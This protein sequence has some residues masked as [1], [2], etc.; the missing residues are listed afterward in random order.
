MPQSSKAWDKKSQRR[1]GQFRARRRILILCEDEKSS[2]D[3]FEHFPLSEKNK[4]LI[5]I[6]CV[7][8]GYN[9]D[10]L[11]EEAIRRREVAISENR[12]YS[13]IWVVFDK[14]DFPQDRFNRAFQL[15]AKYSNVTA[16][17]ANESFELW[18]LLHFS[19]HH[20][21]IG[22]HAINVKLSG[23]L[24][25]NGCVNRDYDKSDKEMYR[26]LKGRLGTAIS[27]AKKLAMDNGAG[28]LQRRN[29]ST[30]IHILVN[31]LMEFAA[32]D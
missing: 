22:R 3:Y 12:P 19:Y 18:Y 1:R 16:V 17:W 15:A 24:R 26:Y 5:D 30:N 25:R 27:Y 32:D 6:Q 20:T 28:I 8:T 31:K 29:P 23:L 14:D 13:S 7:G 4:E 2:R 9:T 10:T 21:A 11:M